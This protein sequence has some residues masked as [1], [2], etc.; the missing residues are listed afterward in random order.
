[1]LILVVVVVVVLVVVAIVASLMEECGRGL[2][3]E[4]VE[5]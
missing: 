3:L 1:M 5:R 2:R 4:Y